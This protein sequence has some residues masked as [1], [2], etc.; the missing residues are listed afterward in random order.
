MPVQG[1][2]VRELELQ[3]CVLGGRAA[4]VVDALEQ[5]RRLTEL[6]LRLVRPGP[7]DVARWLESERFGRD[8]SGFFRP[9]PVEAASLMEYAWGSAVADETALGDALYALRDMGPDLRAIRDRLRGVAWCYFMH[10]ANGAL[11][12][13]FLRLDRNIAPSFDWR[14]YRPFRLAHPEN[15]PAGG[16]VW[17]Q[18]TVDGG[19]EGLVTT[20]AVPVFHEGHLAGVWAIDMPLRWLQAPTHDPTGA[21]DDEETTSGGA[22]PWRRL[23]L[24][25][26]EGRILA[27]PG[28][29]R[30]APRGHVHAF[31][32]ASLGGGYTALD[33]ADLRRRRRGER[34][35]TGADGQRVVCAF[36]AVEGTDWLL[37][38]TASPRTGEPVN[39]PPLTP[40]SSA[41]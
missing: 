18:P 15:N 12:H 5:L 31:T 27:H 25:D 30:A 13:P 1:S 33:A 17:T 4:R 28:L 22:G 36:Q 14:E 29:H 11:L 20:G 41:A 38:L 6:R 23:F 7:H 39:A 21:E 2:V 16:V 24:V 40:A 10:V 37:L 9:Q 3:A 26:A 8:P 32:L 35:L 19:G 34:E